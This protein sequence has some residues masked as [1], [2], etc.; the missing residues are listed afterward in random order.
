[1]SDAQ[2]TG[3]EADAS[4]AAASADPLVAAL[5]DSS[6]ARARCCPDDCCAKSLQRGRQ[7]IFTHHLSVHLRLTERLAACCVCPRQLHRVVCSCLQRCFCCHCRLVDDLHELQAF[8]TQRA[9][10]LASGAGEALSASAP[11]AVQVKHCRV[12]LCVLSAGGIRRGRDQWH[13]TSETLKL[14][15]LFGTL[16]RCTV[17]PLH[18]PLS[19]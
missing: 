19:A 6:D 3:N 11:E 9:A 5:M 8:L 10:E 7:K 4:S 14:P 17:S 18:H 16:L 2:R 15:I 12:P 1:M 13:W